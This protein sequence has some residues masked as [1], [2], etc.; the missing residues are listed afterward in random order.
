MLCS[1]SIENTPYTV[2][3]YRRALLILEHRIIYYQLLR[4]ISRVHRN[5]IGII[6]LQKQKGCALQHFSKK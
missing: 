3:R 4:D 2:V 1:K 6:L 5:T